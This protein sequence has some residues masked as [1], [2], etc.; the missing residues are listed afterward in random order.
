MRWIVRLTIALVALF[1]TIA[2][3]AA[4]RHQFLVEEA[5][6]AFP[7][8]GS[9]VATG[10]RDLHVVCRGEGAPVVIFESGLGTDSTLAWA[11][12]ADQVSKRTKACFYDRAGYGWSDAAP[13]PR[14]LAH[15]ARE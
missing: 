8:P 3:G 2:V 10:G 12:V 5:A 6:K 13:P 4:A 9:F 1:A 11:R 14:D 7:P 15:L